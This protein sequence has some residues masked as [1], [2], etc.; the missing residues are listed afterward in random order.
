[1]EADIPLLIGNTTLIRGLGI[2]DTPNM[3]LVLLGKKLKLNKT[4]SGFFSLM[5]KVPR[6]EDER[7][8]TI[9]D[10]SLKD[11]PRSA[12]VLPRAKLSKPDLVLSE[13]SSSLAALPIQETDSDSL[14]SLKK[15]EAN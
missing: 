9:E 1:M 10:K 8:A 11:K 14:T 15:Q 6:G 4:E 3:E 2:I 12:V 5:V 7:M 13:V